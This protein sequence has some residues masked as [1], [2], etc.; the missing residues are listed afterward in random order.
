MASYAAIL[1]YSLNVKSHAFGTVWGDWKDPEG[2]FSAVTHIVGNDLAVP[3][4]FLLGA[5]IVMLNVVIFF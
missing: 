1:A 3:T 4:G 5:L 2:E